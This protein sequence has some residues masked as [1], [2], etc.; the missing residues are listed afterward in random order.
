MDIAADYCAVAYVDLGDY[1]IIVFKVFNF[2][3][4]KF[5]LCAAL[6]R[7]VKALLYLKFVIVIKNFGE[8]AGDD[9]VLFAERGGFGYP[10]VLF[11]IGDAL[12]FGSDAYD[13]VYF[14]HAGECAD[15]HN[16]ADQHKR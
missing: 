15:Q 12:V 1:I 7:K 2:V 11:E 10:A 8:G 4:I 14:S 5:Y 13:L 3:C 16:Y 6:L 9:D